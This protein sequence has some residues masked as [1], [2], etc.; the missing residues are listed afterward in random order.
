M[1]L[2]LPAGLTRDAGGGVIKD[3][4]REVRDRIA[5]VFTS[6]LEQ[7]SVGKVMRSFA[8]RDLSVPQCDR[9]GEAVWRPATLDRI[10]RILKNPAYAGAFVY[11]RTRCR[12]TPYCNGKRGS[13][14]RP[15]AEWKIVVKDKYPAYIDWV[16]PELLIYN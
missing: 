15:M 12:P 7:G 4:D 11:G 1:A 6:F 13:V 16:R 3:P 14:P 8:R 2:A 9:F 10:T 5:L